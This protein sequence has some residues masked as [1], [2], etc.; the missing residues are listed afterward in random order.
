MLEFL[1]TIFLIVYMVVIGVYL[2][3]AVKKY[4]SDRIVFKP[5]TIV[6]V[7]IISSFILRGCG[8]DLD[9]T[10]YQYRGGGPY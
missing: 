10:G 7:L 4:P 6:L 3:T 2:Y 5:I 9:N 8:L 1:R